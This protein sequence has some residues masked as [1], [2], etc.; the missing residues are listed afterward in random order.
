VRLN[1][2]PVGGF[3]GQLLPAGAF[4]VTGLAAR[5]EAAAGRP[6]REVSE[7]FPARALPAADL[8]GQVFAA[9]GFPAREP[10]AGFAPAARAGRRSGDSGMGMRTFR[11]IHFELQ[12]R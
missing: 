7:V 5:G 10:V 4:P 2:L 1:S 3:A 12:F 9:A 11:E 6:A 8:P